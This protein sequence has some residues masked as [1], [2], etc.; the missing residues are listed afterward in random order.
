MRVTISQT[1]LTSIPHLINGCSANTM[2]YLINF[3]K[4]FENK[5]YNDTPHGSNS[6]TPSLP[7]DLDDF[8][9]IMNAYNY[10]GWTKEDIET[11][12]ENAEKL[13]FGKKFLTF[14]DNF[15]VL[16]SFYDGGEEDE[17]DFKEL[18]DEIHYGM[19]T[20]EDDTIE[21][22]LLGEF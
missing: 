4:M 9:R 2:F 16:K 6:I 3:E 10:F 8:G 17:E 13:K 14:L 21:E 12:K 1:K 7:Y 19:E 11:A 5:A 15:L 18:L 20:S 22:L